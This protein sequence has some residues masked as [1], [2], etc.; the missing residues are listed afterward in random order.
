M[1]KKAKGGMKCSK[2]KPGKKC[3]G[4]AAKKGGKRKSMA[5]GY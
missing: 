5:S 1:K 4:C 3:K 2:C